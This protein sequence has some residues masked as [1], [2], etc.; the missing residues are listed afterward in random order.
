[1]LVE[2]LYIL[3]LLNPGHRGR[4]R[5]GKKKEAEKKETTAVTTGIH[6]MVL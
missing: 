6:K 1:M 2:T 4:G 5:R 3:S